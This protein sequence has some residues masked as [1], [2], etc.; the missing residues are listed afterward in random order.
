MTPTP[1]IEMYDLKPCPY[2]G[3]QAMYV[4]GKVGIGKG[5]HWI[6]CTQPV[7][8]PVYPQSVGGTEAEAVSK[9]NAQAEA[10]G[11]AGI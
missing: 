5:L 2:C 7:T 4:P 6:I 8:C 10:A 9:W 1:L 11:E 3:A